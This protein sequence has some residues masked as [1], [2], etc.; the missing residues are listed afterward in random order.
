MSFRRLPQNRMRRF[1]S[2]AVALVFLLQTFAVA[3]MPM[4]RVSADGDMIVICTSTGMKTVSLSQFLGAAADQNLD[5]DQDQDVD[6]AQAAPDALSSDGM[7]PLCLLAHQVAIVPAL[8]YLC[9]T[10]LNTHAPQAPPVDAAI[11]N[12]FYRTQQARAPPSNA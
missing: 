7:C 2:L 5:Q 9:A 11:R 1:G 10:D 4:M 8:D 6:A 12:A 3:S